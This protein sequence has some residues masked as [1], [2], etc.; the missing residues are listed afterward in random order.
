M[1]SKKTHPGPHLYE[2]VAYGVKGYQVFRCQV[3]NCSHFMSP[4]SLV[5]NKISQCWLHY[6]DVCEGS[7][8]IT[9]DM[10]IPGREVKQPACESCRQYRT[11]LKMD[12][13]RREM[14]DQDKIA[15][16]ED[17]ERQKKELNLNFAINTG[18]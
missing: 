15:K 4:M 10:L 3:P 6:K 5:E 12:E 1:A 11:D 14:E 16:R 13:I 18:V 7:V 8:I 17:F 9:K 2:R